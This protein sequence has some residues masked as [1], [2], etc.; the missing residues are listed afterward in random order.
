[1]TLV[2]RIGADKVDAIFDVAYISSN[3]PQY[4][5]L[6]RDGSYLCTCLLLQNCGIVCRHFFRLMMD[7]KCKYHIAL[8]R[9]RWYKEVLQDDSDLDPS[10]EPFAYI[11]LIQKP[12]DADA[13]MSDTYMKDILA[14]FST[15]ASVP[16]SDAAL[17]SSNDDT[18]S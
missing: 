1:M 9:R 8:V 5:V 16:R 18:E 6:L 11:G 7:G 14:A 17:V 2:S 4:V 13:P 3:R 10:K 15:Q 12:V